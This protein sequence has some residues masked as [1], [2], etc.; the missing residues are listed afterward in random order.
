[1]S[2][3]DTVVLHGTDL[4]QP[5]RTV[6]WLLRMHNVPFEYQMVMPGAKKGTKSP[7]FIQKK[8]RFGT[9][10]VLEHNGNV[11][12]ESA[13]IVVYLAEVFKWD[14]LYPSNNPGKKAEINSWMHW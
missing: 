7:E 3:K 5:C 4:S 2:S 13:A 1:M 8:N 6:S 9:V 11:I 10:P 12:S 14:D